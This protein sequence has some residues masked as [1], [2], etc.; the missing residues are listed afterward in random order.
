MN[1]KP[2]RE[3]PIRGHA[4]EVEDE[5]IGTMSSRA[6]R[7]ADPKARLVQRDTLVM[8]V[9]DDPNPPRLIRLETRS[10]RGNEFVAISRDSI[11]AENEIPPIPQLE[12]QIIPFEI[13]RGQQ[14]EFEM[15]RKSLGGFSQ[16]DIFGLQTRDF[17]FEFPKMGDTRAEY[18]ILC[19]HGKTA[20]A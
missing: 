18:E 5:A 16:R 8:S 3:A 10:S 19:T 20:N 17:G 2:M 14:S 13:P 9:E 1:L 7:I 15:G 4:R 6:T 11:R 12:N